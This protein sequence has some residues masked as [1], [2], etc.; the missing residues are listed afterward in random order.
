[1]R[2]EVLVFVSVQEDLALLLAAPHVSIFDFHLPH[3]PSRIL[4]LIFH[5]AI[6]LLQLL[7]LQFDRLQYLQL[8]DSVGIGL[9]H[10][11]EFV[12]QLLDLP[13]CPQKFVLSLP[14]AAVE[15][16]QLGL[17]LVDVGFED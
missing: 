15:G 14:D 1:M 11:V 4:Q 8:V 13:V 17:E 10:G 7:F 3:H 6:V 5:C 12:L 2:G 16:A 9:Q